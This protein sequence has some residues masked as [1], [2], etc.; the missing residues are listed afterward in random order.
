M[1]EE[2]KAYSSLSHWISGDG[3]DSEIVMSSR[4]RLARN[5]KDFVY[6]NIA[7]TESRKKVSEAVKDALTSEDLCLHYIQMSDLP[8]LERELLVEKHLVSPIHAENG[9]G[10]DVFIDDKE[11]ISIMVNE[12][13]HIRLQVLKPG[14]QLNK[15]WE[16]ASEIDDRLEQKLDFAFSERWGYL[17]AC[18]TNVGT[19]LRAS[20]MVHLPALNFT[21]NA[22]KLLSA[23]SRLGRARRGLY[24]EGSESIGNI[25]Q[26][27]NQVTLG[28][29]EMD[30]IENLNSVT[31]EIINQEKKARE[32]L[33]NDI[34]VK[35]R[36]RR[37]YGVLRYAYQISSE[38]AMN[39]ISHVRLGIDM[40]IINDVDPRVLGE[41]MILI[42]PAHIQKIHGRE[43]DIV[44]RDI[45]RAELIQ[46]RLSI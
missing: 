37:S 40:G 42:R 26:I 4:I 41:L 3:P 13:D 29:T 14:M 36:I 38:E 22:A 21:N 43:L 45:K 9:T 32:G 20:V 18:P 19:G 28:H 12:E 34:K 31:S 6:P 23:V 16:I 27:S 10:K 8:E 24:G 35:D 11:S 30:I 5:L 44:E 25:Y 1:G 15:A 2:N 17:T 33:M 39:L 7:D 46:N